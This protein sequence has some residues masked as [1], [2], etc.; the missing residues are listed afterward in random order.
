M[1]EAVYDHR[2]VFDE[3]GYNLK[4]LDIQGVMGLQQIDKLPEL[5]SAR[6]ENFQKL[7]KIFSK[8]EKYFHLPKP[9]EK[10]DPCWFGYLLTIKE[11]CPF[12]K[13]K[14]VDYLE[15]NKIQTRSYFTG[16]ALAHPAYWRLAQQYKDIRKEFPIATYVTTNTFF[17]GTFIGIDDE[18]MNY[19]EKVVNKFFEEQI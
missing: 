3:I 17:L 15:N 13:Q 14:F 7:T 5:E 4:P 8:Y 1:P 11:D 16:N 9:T 10:S 2:Y 19:I 6:R 18:K 12:T